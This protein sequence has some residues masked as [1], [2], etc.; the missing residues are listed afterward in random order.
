MQEFIQMLQY[1]VAKYSKDT[2]V[3]VNCDMLKFSENKRLDIFTNHVQM[4]NNPKFLSGFFVDQV[5]INNSL[6]KECFTNAT[7]GN[8]YFSDHNAVRII[9]EKNAF[10]FYTIP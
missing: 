6:M 1:Q 2:I 7:V 8:I 4:V 9:I 3:D 5:Y 10:D